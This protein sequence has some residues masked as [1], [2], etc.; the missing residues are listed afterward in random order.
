MNMPMRALCLPGAGVFD[1]KDRASERFFELVGF[2]P[3]RHPWALSRVRSQAINSLFDLAGKP[4]SNQ[5]LALQNFLMQV[6]DTSDW[7]QM[8]HLVQYLTGTRL[9]D[10]LAPSRVAVHPDD[11]GLDGDNWFS[12]TVELTMLGGTQKYMISHTAAIASNLDHLFLLIRDKA[13][14]KDSYDFL[15]TRQATLISAGSEPRGGL[16]P[17]FV[18]VNKNNGYMMQLPLI[19][20]KNEGEFEMDWGKIRFGSNQAV[21]RAI[22]GAAPP[23]VANK[24]KGKH[25][26]EG[27]GL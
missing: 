7:A 26:E 11:H 14:H 23:A 15:N 9:S 2:D 13:L 1:L 21:F 24:I 20:G 22:I 18:T 5:S 16:E 17:I 3:N 27:L 19:D 8:N 6:D 25:L 10:V 12:A 4:T